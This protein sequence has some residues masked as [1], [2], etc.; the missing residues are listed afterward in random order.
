MGE[1]LNN[2]NIESRKNEL[3]SINKLYETF[4]YSSFDLVERYNISVGFETGYKRLLNIVGNGELD[5]DIFY[6][7]PVGIIS[8]FL[9]MYFKDRGGN[10]PEVWS[11]NN[12][13]YLKT[14]FG[15]TCV[16]FEAE[17]LITVNH[18]EI[19]NVY[20]R[21]FVKG[22]LSVFE[23]LFP[24]I[25]INFF[26]KSSRRTGEDCVEGFQIVYP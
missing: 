25:K 12:I 21:S 10:L 5:N 13:V 14:E 22:M 19:C 2:L 9:F 18:R 23:E 24:G 4:G 3:E 16:T 6:A 15:K 8:N 17:K 26:N 11:D 7:D 1:V 20:C